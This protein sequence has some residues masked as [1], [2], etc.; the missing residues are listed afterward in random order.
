M[1]QV[2]RPPAEIGAE[3]IVAYFDARSRYWRDVYRAPGVQGEVYRARQDAALELFAGLGIPAGSP[4]LDAGC[5]AGRLALE[6]ARR[7]FRVAAVDAS[8]QMIEAARQ[9]LSPVP[10]T[11]P[12]DVRQA[13]V[14]RLPFPAGTFAAVFALGLLPW[15]SDPAAALSEISRVTKAGGHV[16]V[17]ADNRGRLVAA[18]DP[19]LNTELQPIKQRL[20]RSAAAAG[21]VSVPP[22][23]DARLD[24]PGAVDALLLEAGF[25]PVAA[26]TVGFGPFT[27]FRRHA[28]PA[29]AALRLHRWL[30]V[31]A[32]RGRWG[33]AGRGA[34][35]L[36]AAQLRV[37]R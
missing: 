19:W 20:R 35:Y 24:A 3:P 21:L 15:L 31:R 37:G 7:G 18:L 6:L 22:A 25:E 33:L 17:S 26:R 34:H 23:V 29:P 2:A 10:S 14:Y 27:L 11:S 4:V 1:P 16:I 8:P 28:L 36:V 5:G 32:D 13:S 9:T 12:V 30:Q